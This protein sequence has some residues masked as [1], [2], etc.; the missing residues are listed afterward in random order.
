MTTEIASVAQRLED[1]GYRLTSERQGVLEYVLT[2]TEPFSAEDAV[3]NLR[4]VGRATVFRTI[5]LLLDLD[6]I[7]RIIREDGG[8]SYQL[9]R[10]G[11][12][13]HLV[14]VQCGRVQDFSVCTVPQ[15]V[16][17]LASNADFTIEGHRLEIYGHC[18]ACQGIAQPAV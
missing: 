5:K 16:S 7:C 3:R 8:I 9:S 10:R 1:L 15:M 2:T 14:C 17:E 6:V 18:G 4:S 13:H 12:H 11:H